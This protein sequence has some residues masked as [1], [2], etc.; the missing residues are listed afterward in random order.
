MSELAKLVGGISP[1]FAPDGGGG[2]GGS[3][4]ANTGGT[5]AATPGGG[6]GG[7]PAAT[8]SGGEGGQSTGG[9]PPAMDFTPA[10]A[11]QPATEPA[12]DPAQQQ[13]Q[14]ATQPAN[15]PATEPATDPAQQQEPVT[16][17]QE[18]KGEGEPTPILS[19]LPAEGDQQQ[20]QQQTEPDLI[21]G[22]FENQE[23]LVESWKQLNDLAKGR[24]NEIPDATILEVAKDRGLIT[25]SGDVAAAQVP[26]AYDFQ[27]AIPE[28]S[29]FQWK[30]VEEAPEAYAHINDT[31]KAANITQEG[32]NTIMPL[33]Q[34]IV[35][36]SVEDFGAHVNVEAEKGKLSEGWG[37]DVDARGRAVKEYVISNLGRDIFYK[38]LGA[39]AAGM[40]LL[41]QFMNGQTGQRTALVP[42]PGETTRTPTPSLNPEVIDTKK[43]EVMASE[44]YKNPMHPDHERA[45]QT[46]R[47]LID[48]KNDLL[49]R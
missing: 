42:E 26:E 24:S 12:T 16:R 8:P 20:Q 15:E 34:E 19:D 2:G 44:A 35:Q 9:D 18:M 37:R 30:S 41:E 14:P 6:E 46:Y 45:Q 1:V 3:P 13:Q 22:R 32:L 48:Q 17:T 33:V 38:P 40:Q 11:A 25:D 29:S 36:Q 10:P 5:P 4:P 31:L 39:T 43:A 21:L 49:G 28:G 7:T 47:D 23:A 27:A